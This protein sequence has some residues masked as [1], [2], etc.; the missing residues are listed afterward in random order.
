MHVN[1]CDRLLNISAPHT[2][3]E[4]T[5]EPPLAGFPGLETM[6]PLLLTA[7]HNNTLT[8]QVGGSGDGWMWVGG[9]LVGVGGCG[10]AVGG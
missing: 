10:W 7:V 4:K 1:A 2:L 9:R 6:L 5:G 3:A 8:L